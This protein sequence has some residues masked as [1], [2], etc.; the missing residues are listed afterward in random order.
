MS[1]FFTPV[2]VEPLPKPDIEPY[3]IEK[4]H[5]DPFQPA[6]ILIES[7]SDHR[8]KVMLW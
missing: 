3:E 6:S 7:L 5:N 2:E 4:F 1:I 8:K